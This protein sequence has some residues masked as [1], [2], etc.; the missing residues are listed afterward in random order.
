MNGLEKLTKGEAEVLRQ[1]ASGMCVKEI[2]QARVT[3][4]NTVRSQV[5]NMLE[6]LGVGTQLKAVAIYHQNELVE[7]RKAAL[8][9]AGQ[10]VRDHVF[11]G[12]GIG[13]RVADFL[14]FRAARLTQ[15]TI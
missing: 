10:L 12:T 3:S 9:E 2:A 5:K 15:P 8:K 7:T 11:G 13:E 14:D 1:L 4:V 6:K